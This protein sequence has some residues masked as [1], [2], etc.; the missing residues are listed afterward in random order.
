MNYTPKQLAKA[1][2]LVGQKSKIYYPWKGRF[3]HR[4]VRKDHEGYYVL[5]QNEK[6][7]LRLALND[8]GEMVCF[9]ML[10]GRR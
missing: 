1:D 3:I 8:F 6:K 10:H 7:R 5:Y 9:E 4:V 2:S